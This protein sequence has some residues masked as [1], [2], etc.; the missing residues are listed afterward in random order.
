MRTFKLFS[1]IAIAG[2]LSACVHS[3][4]VQKRASNDL[5]RADPVYVAS[6]EHTARLRGTTVQ[7]VNPPRAVDRRRD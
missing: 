5:L 4:P 2:L 7:W 1:I 3:G 6:V